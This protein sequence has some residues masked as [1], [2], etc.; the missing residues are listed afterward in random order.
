MDGL[1]IRRVTAADVTRII[2]RA[3]PQTGR[4]FFGVI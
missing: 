1:H 3:S 4:Y 2:V